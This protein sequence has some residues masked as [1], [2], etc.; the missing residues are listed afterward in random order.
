MCYPHNGIDFYTRGSENNFSFYGL[1]MKKDKYIKEFSELLDEFKPD[2]IHFFGTEFS[3]SY[4]LLKVCENKNYLDNSVVSIQ[5]L[6]SVYADHFFPCISN[7]W[8]YLFTL[9]ELIHKN[10]LQMNYKNYVTRG[11]DEIEEIKLAKNIIGRTTWDKAC[12]LRMNSEINYYFCNETLRS[13]FYVDSWSYELC[14]KH[15][16]YISQSTKPLKGFHIFLKALSIVV[17]T[18]PD[19]KVYVAGDSFI[20]GNWIHGSTYGMYIKHLLKS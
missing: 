6:V 14:D 18:F 10:T 3:R 9:T 4:N 16:I 15:T 17:K 11:L 8:K 7:K 12:A 13:S 1:S 2:V 19:T 20:N 5:G